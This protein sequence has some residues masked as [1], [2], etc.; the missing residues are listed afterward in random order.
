MFNT[1]TS[2][3]EDMI[4]SIKPLEVQELF[5][6]KQRGAFQTKRVFTGFLSPHSLLFV[7]LEE[8]VFKPHRLIC[9]MTQSGTSGHSLSEDELEKTSL[10]LWVE[11]EPFAFVSICGYCFV[12]F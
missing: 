4:S 12:F 5:P 1:S 3:L 6:Q 8:R 11:V 10:H 2:Q 9:H 7:W